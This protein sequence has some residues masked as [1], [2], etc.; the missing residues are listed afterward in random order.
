[1]RSHYPKL[2]VAS[3]LLSLFLGAVMVAVSS[4][5]FADSASYQRLAVNVLRGHGYSQADVPPFHPDLARA[6]GYPALL[7]A[8]YALAGPGNQLAVRLLQIVLNASLPFFVFAVARRWLREGRA[9]ALAGLLVALYLPLT[10][11]SSAVLSDG[12][13]VWLLAAAV[14]TW[15]KG[16]PAQENTGVRAAAW[17]LLAG[18]LTGLAALTRPVLLLLGPCLALTGVR[19]RKWAVLVMIGGW[20]I[21]VAPWTIRNYLVADSFIPVSLGSGYNLWLGNAEAI[22]I[23]EIRRAEFTLCVRGLQKSSP[24]SQ[25]VAADRAFFQ[26]G[27]GLLCQHPWPILQAWA[28]RSFTIWMAKPMD[29]PLLRALGIAGGAILLLLAGVGAYRRPQALLPALLVVGY[30]S[31]CHAPFHSVA[32]MALPAGPWLLVMA[33][34]GMLSW[35]RSRAEAS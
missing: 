4:G 9:P 23:T 5:W 8:I 13:A 22:G 2:A 34:V 35:R 3:C 29:R 33:A 30:V 1:M 25:A 14:W 16:S 20:L 10:Y 11:W 32:R 26:T 18:M 24:P 17:C 12:L 19:A 21:A 7:T 31:L 27:I 28:V 6:P 15:S